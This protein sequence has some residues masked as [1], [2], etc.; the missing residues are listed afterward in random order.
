[1]VVMC[2]EEIFKVWMIQLWKFVS[3]IALNSYSRTVRPSSSYPPGIWTNSELEQFN[4]SFFPPPYDLFLWV[5]SR[6]L[7]NFWL[8]FSLINAFIASGIADH[9]GFRNVWYYC[10][11]IRLKF[12]T[13]LSTW[14]STQ[15]RS[16]DPASAAMALVK[17][18]TEAVRVGCV[19][20][21]NGRY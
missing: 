7:T 3:F 6:R 19:D 16:K 11:T 13:S 8:I 5:P 14:V 20:R 21:A 17:V 10:G 9:F 4:S 18:R 15:C 1:M 2:W 12:S